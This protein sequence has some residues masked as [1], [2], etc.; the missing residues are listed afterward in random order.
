MNGSDDMTLRFIPS[1][2]G[3]EIAFNWIFVLIAG[4]FLLPIFGLSGIRMAIL[5]AEV[6]LMVANTFI[7]IRGELKSIGA[8][9]ELMFTWYDG[10]CFLSV[11]GFL[12]L[13]VFITNLNMMYYLISL[14]VLLIGI[15]YSWVNLDIEIRS[16]I[17]RMFKII[18]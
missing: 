13:N 12:L 18:R 17:L 14:I 5:L 15:I 2:K 3:F 10:L 16:R 8:K 1:K 6:L 7:F 9:R 4:Y 11:L